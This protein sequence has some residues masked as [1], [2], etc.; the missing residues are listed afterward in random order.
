MEVN[1][2]F[3]YLVICFL[4]LFVDDVLVGFDEDSNVEMCK[5]GDILMFDF[6]FKVY[7][8]LGESLG[9][10]DFDW[11]VKVVGVC[12]VYYKDVGVFL[13]WVVYSFMLDLYI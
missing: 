1:D 11:V 4:N 8:E 2:W 3:Y 12:F 5:Y 10:L 6:K 13:E 9:I 7:W